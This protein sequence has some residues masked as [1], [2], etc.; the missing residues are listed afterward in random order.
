MTVYYYLNFSLIK[1]PKIG[2][3]EILNFI[4]E[5]YWKQTAP[6]EGNI[7]DHPMQW[8]LCGIFCKDKALF[9]REIGKPMKAKRFGLVMTSLLSVRPP[10]DVM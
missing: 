7:E 1:T 10:L 2:N 6:M 3:S 8:R 5:N 9:I 4:V